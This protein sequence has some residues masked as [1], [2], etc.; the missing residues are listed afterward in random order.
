MRRGRLRRLAGS[1]K[2]FTLM[3]ALVACALFAIV[4]LA[5]ASVFATGLRIWKRATAEREGIAVALAVAEIC[6]RREQAR[7]FK[8]LDGPAASAGRMAFVGLVGD[9][10]RD[11]Q[12]G[13]VEYWLDESG[14]LLRRERS[15][16]EV[17]SEQAGRTV[18]L[19]DSVDS[20]QVEPLFYS[21]LAGSF[22]DE[23]ALGTMSSEF[24]HGPD[25]LRIAVGYRTLDGRTHVL[26]RVVLV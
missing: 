6:E 8:P 22:Q 25:A 2:G 10:H 23:P 15:Y 21:E 1:V 17:D 12:L 16:S 24:E 7:R 18:E 20:F 26:E 19:A 3:E 14:A 9:S 11:R 4:A 13:I 5:L